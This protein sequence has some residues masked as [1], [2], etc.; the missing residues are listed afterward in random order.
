MG[1]LQIDIDYQRGDFAL[2][3]AFNAR[4]GLTAFFGRSGSGK[5][6]LANIIAGLLKPDRGSI[7]LGERLLFDSNKGVIVPPEKRRIGY[8]FQEGRLFPHLSVR[9]NL[10]FAQR[11][12]PG[13]VTPPKIHE[14]TA[15]LDLQHLLERR[16]QNLSGGE[17]QRV[18]IG[19]AL[20]SAPRLL[21]MD[22]PLASLD[23]THKSEIL[24]FIERLRDE[25]GIPIIYVSHALDE[26]IRLADTMVILDHGEGVASGSVEEIM[27]RLDLRPLT[28]RYEAGAVLS[29]AIRGHDKTYGLSELGFDGGRLWVP[30]LDAPLGTEL[31]MRIRARDVSLSLSRPTDTSILNVLEAT[32]KEIAPADGPQTE[33]LLDIGVPLIARITRRSVIAMDLQPGKTVYAL[34]KAASID[35]HSL[36]MGGTRQRRN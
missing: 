28:G 25:I 14:I 19:R 23:A 20:M 32:V 8:V 35:R 16:T 13:D 36:G 34:I 26:V 22:E 31:R 21:V 4:P 27:G 7:A 1:Q 15:L 2:R 11:F 29:V 10:V 18:A 3:A 33:V 24:P 6:T 17:K 30:G 9:K 5:T 12:L